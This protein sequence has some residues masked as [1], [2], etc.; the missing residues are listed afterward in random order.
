MTQ[1]AFLQ[2][3]QV[4][5]PQKH[6]YRLAR[7][8]EEHVWQTSFFR[9]PSSQPRWLYTTHLEGNEQA[10]KKHHGALDQAV[11]MYASA[12]YLILQSEFNL[13]GMGPGGF[14]ENFTVEGLAEETVCLADI[15]AIGEAHVQVTGPRYPCAKIEKRWNMEGLAT[16]LARTGRTGWYCQVLQEGMVE[17]EMPVTLLERSYPQWTIALINALAH[18]QNKDREKAKELLHCPFLSDFWKEI[19]NHRFKN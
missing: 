12:N 8:G 16:H 17:P 18:G 13:P 5:S 19:I 7:D 14:G 2:T 11:L 10:D 9:T 1:V 6:T 4:G 15:Y 3:V